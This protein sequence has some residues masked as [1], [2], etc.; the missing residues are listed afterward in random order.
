MHFLRLTLGEDTGQPTSFYATI[1]GGSFTLLPTTTWGE[2]DREGK[3]SVRTL[4]AN[5]LAML[6]FEFI[7][8]VVG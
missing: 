4:A 6:S 7:S 3:R 1:A 2:P 5:V 8:R